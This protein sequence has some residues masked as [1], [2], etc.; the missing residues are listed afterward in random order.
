[1]SILLGRGMGRNDAEPLWTNSGLESGIGMRELISIFKTRPNLPE[2]ACWWLWLSF[3]SCCGLSR[4]LSSASRPFRCPVEA[5]RPPSSATAATPSPS[6]IRPAAGR[7]V[8]SWR[9]GTCLGAKDCLAVW[10]H[11]KATKGRTWRS[12]RTSAPD[13]TKGEKCGLSGSMWI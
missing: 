8:D 5:V 12:K 7:S 10:I 11:E 2:Q 1:M 6:S 9:T 3:C 4:R 13:L